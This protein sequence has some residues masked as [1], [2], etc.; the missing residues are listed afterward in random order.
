MTTESQTRKEL[1]DKKLAAAGWDLSNLTQVVEE[2]DIEIG[3]EEG[4][5]EAWTQRTFKG[6]L[7]GVETV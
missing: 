6:E 5:A 4:V 7:S 1:I 2:F 3:L